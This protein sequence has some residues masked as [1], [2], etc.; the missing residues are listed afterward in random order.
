MLKSL[1]PTV[2]AVA[3]ILAACGG[4]ATVTTTTDS[5]TT[6]SALPMETQVL[7]YHLTA[8]AVYTYDVELS[9]KIDMTAEGS[10][11]AIGDEEIPGAANIEISA[12][13]AFTY[14]IAA[15]PEAGTYEVTITGEFTEVSAT[16]VVDGEQ[17]DSGEVPGFAEIPPVD[18]TI[19]VDEQGNIVPE[20]SDIEDPMA[21]MFGG[22]EDLTGIPGSDPAQF[23]GPPFGDES[24]TVGSNWE[25]VYETPGPGSDPIVTTTRAS[26][27]GT[28][29]V[30]GVELL[31]I[32]SETDVSPIDFDLAEFFIGFFTAF[33]PTDPTPEEQANLDAMVEG[34]RF[35]IS[36]D[37]THSVSTTRFDPESGITHDFDTSNTSNVGMDI[38]FPD[39]ASGELTGFVMEMRLDQTISLEL[40]SGPEA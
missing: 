30:A 18:M 25:S 4:G 37:A 26:V 21:G 34:L 19:I 6:T 29:T 10:G 1:A 33:M 40:V 32:R 38:N 3:L 13:G 31:V 7:A 17:I 9:Q 16:G 20:K 22:M 28:E 12:K 2:T 27:T 14:S 36:V 39:D 8:G 5:T 24:V 35:A 11:E 23:F 15:G